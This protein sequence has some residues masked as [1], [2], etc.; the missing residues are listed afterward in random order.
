M[1]SPPPPRGKA[2]YPATKPAPRLGLTLIELVAA[3]AI[4][5]LT[6][7]LLM[8]AVNAT[9]A[10][11][12]HTRSR[13]AQTTRAMTLLDIIGD[14]LAQAACL[15]NDSDIAADAGFEFFTTNIITFQTSGPD[16]TLVRVEKNGGDVSASNT[17]ASAVTSLCL[18]FDENEETGDAAIVSIGASAVDLYIEL[19]PPELLPRLR[20]LE[21]MPD[22]TALETFIRNNAT[23]AARRVYLP[24]L[25]GEIYTNNRLPRRTATVSLSGRV[26]G[27]SAHFDHPNGPSASAGA[28]G[29]YT[30]DEV[31]AFAPFLIRPETGDDTG[32]FSPAWRV[33]QPGSPTN[34]LDFVWF[35]TS[36]NT[37]RA[38]IRGTVTR[39]DVTDRGV[40]R[41][42]VVLSSGRTTRT[43]SDG[44]YF[45]SVTPGTEETLTVELN[46]P[47]GGTVVSGGDTDFNFIWTPPEITISGTTDRD[48]AIHFDGGAY[49]IPSQNRSSGDYAV[50]TTLLFDWQGRVTATEQ[51]YNSALFPVYGYAIGPLYANRG[52]LDFYDE[53]IEGIDYLVEGH[54]FS[55]LANPTNRVPLPDIPVHLDMGTNIAVR[56]TDNDGRYFFRLRGIFTG[57]LHPEP[58]AEAFAQPFFMPPSVM[59]RDINSTVRQDFTLYASDTELITLAGFILSDPVLTNHPVHFMSDTNFVGDIEFPII[60][61]S[62]HGAFTNRA[63]V[64]WTGFI[65]PATNALAPAFIPPFEVFTNLTS[66]ATN[67]TFTALTNAIPDQTE[68]TP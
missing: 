58:P 6:C 50:T 28:G 15:T 26:E 55:T 36:N 30:L 20:Q 5:A 12:R 16:F 59:L 19:L 62:G 23:R 65:Y 22:E 33:W 64:P 13:A 18:A 43:D 25:L 66:S 44:N 24:N 53:L 11:W 67:L 8:M 46:D 38:T 48:A 37:S 31:P 7:G 40:R 32:S 52:G 45:F 1:K 9:L 63:T 61:A 42:P 2:P 34:G 41:M 54:T 60:H 39:S 49:N 3:V 68:E 14:E 21:D 10:N 57:L 51:D 47:W 17:L 56:T 27:N 4:F 35:S 29:T